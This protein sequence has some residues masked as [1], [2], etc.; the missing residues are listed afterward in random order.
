MSRELIERI[1]AEIVA[2]EADIATF[3]NALG[4]DAELGAEI[5]TLAVLK[6]CKAALSQE[7][8]PVAWIDL[9][10]M[11]PS[12]MVYATG[13]KANDRQTALYASP[14]KPAPL[15]QHED[16]AYLVACEIME[17]HQ[18]ERAMAG[19]EVGTT[20]SLCDGIAWLYDRIATLESEAQKLQHYPEEWGPSDARHLS[21]SICKT[22]FPCATVRNQQP[23]SSVPQDVEKFANDVAEWSQTQFEDVI[24][25]SHFREFM[26]QRDTGH[27]RVP[28]DILGI[29]EFALR[30][31]Q[32]DTPKNGTDY[33]LITRALNVMLTASKGEEDGR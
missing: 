2:L 33:E 11:T 28:V 14:P 20:G 8:E 10:K 21:C 3:K 31:L 26:R 27:A 16:D 23:V 13:F 4:D 18:R 29:S 19:K 12:G 6:D 5:K 15:P 32:F 1:E 17:E 9:S 7:A 22:D 30:R 25:V 24:R